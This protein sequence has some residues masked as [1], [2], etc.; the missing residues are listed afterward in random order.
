MSYASGSWRSAPRASASRGAGIKRS[1]AKDAKDA[2]HTVV[3]L[4]PI[5]PRGAA[6]AA[7]QLAQAL[8]IAVEEHR[9]LLPLPD[10]WA[11]VQR[12]LAIESIRFGERLQLEVDLPAGAMTWLLPSFALQTLVE[13]AVRH[14][15]APRID[16]TRLRIAAHINGDQLIV[17]VA[18]NGAGVDPA[19]L[20]NAPGTGPKRLSE[21]LPW[22]Y[23]SGGSLVVNSTPGAGF[24]ARL[25]LPQRIGETG[26]ADD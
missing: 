19:A 18:D 15:A 1:T 7:E 9:D 26:H 20:A 5:D 24:E 23:G 14:A 11:F 22:L 10:E 8:R 2:L 21:R 13:N 16:P 12:Y 6:H 3:Q 25:T 4:I 17:S